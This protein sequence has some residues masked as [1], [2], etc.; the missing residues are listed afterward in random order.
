MYKNSAA[1]QTYKVLLGDVEGDPLH[2]LQ[3]LKASLFP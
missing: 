3:S 1:T 2:S